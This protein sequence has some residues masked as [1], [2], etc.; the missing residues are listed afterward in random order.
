MMRTK[1]AALGAIPGMFFFDENSNNTP[2]G[3]TE[4]NGG[5]PCDN[6]S[7]REEWNKET[8]Y[9]SRTRQSDGDLPIAVKVKYFVCG[10]NGTPKFPCEIELETLRTYYGLQG[11]TTNKQTKNTGNNMATL[12]IPTLRRATGV[13]G[14]RG[15][16]DFNPSATYIMSLNTLDMRSDVSQTARVNAIVGGGVKGSYNVSNMGARS[17]YEEA[18]TGKVFVDVGLSYPILRELNLASTGT[19]D[20]DCPCENCTTEWRDEQWWLSET[21]ET[22]NSQQVEITRKIIVCDPADGEAVLSCAA[23]LAQL[24]AQYGIQGIRGLGTIPGSQA[25][26]DW[27]LRAAL[28]AHKRGIIGERDIEGYYGDCLRKTL[29]HG[30]PPQLTA[31]QPSLK[32]LGMTAQQWDAGQQ[33]CLAKCGHTPGCYEECMKPLGRRP[34]NM[35]GNGGGFSVTQGGYGMMPVS[36]LPALSG[37]SND[38]SGTI[39]VPP[40]PYVPQSYPQG[41]VIYTTPCEGSQNVWVSGIIGVAIGIL[42][43]LMAQMMFGRRRV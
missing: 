26:K 42:S 21:A 18:G 10:T 43:V 19:T 32:G 15:L 20:S 35:A 1:T 5:C 14:V 4:T 36:A 33:E 2:G 25:D 16:R 34:V 37:L 41:D 11:L 30:A 6:W 29:A 8:R 13:R 28:D 27:C 40:P 12:T 38:A 22:P 9:Y 39:N 23:E 17:V 7:C 31:P 24:K 3:S